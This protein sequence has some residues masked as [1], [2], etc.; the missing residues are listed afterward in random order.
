MRRQAH[1]VDEVIT[2]VEYDR[3]WPGLFEAERVCIADELRAGVTRIEHF[4]ST[5]IP[6][7]AAKPI[8]DLLVGVAELG[9][10]SGLVE[11]ALDRLGYE[12]FGEIFFPGR[13]YLRKRGP[14]HFNAAIAKDS[15]EFWN[16]QIIVRDYL[17]CHSDEAERYS[18]EK[19]ASYLAGATLFSTYSQS[20]GPFL[21]ALK[22][23]AL[24][25][26]LRTDRKSS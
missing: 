22:D 4:G 12:S 18:A 16:A 7:M 23:R 15:G 8:V 11:D 10:P 17:L 1:D 21:E 26:H 24:Q 9:T 20:K 2:I 6:G 25:W 14:P 13:L 5:A 3:R 19:R